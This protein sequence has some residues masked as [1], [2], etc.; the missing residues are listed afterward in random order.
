M[1]R[2]TSR[3]AAACRAAPQSPTAATTA[4]TRSAPRVDKL[5][6]GGSAE[7]AVVHYLR[8]HGCH[9]VAT[10]LRLGRLELDVV[11]RQDRTII[12]VE[13]R[14]RG[15]GAWTTGFGSINLK[16]RQR[17]RRAGERLW[18]ARYKHDSSVDRMRFDAASVTFD[19]GTP[20]VEYAQAAF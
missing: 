13:V 20:V 16:K 8:Q 12:V 17:V 9:I 3:P 15:S 4:R 19:D 7:R 1:A 14:T 6:L 18:R 10:N 5:A 11:A 2:S